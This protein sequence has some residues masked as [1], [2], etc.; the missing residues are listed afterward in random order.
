MRD[1]APDTFAY[2]LGDRVGE[3]METVLE[4]RPIEGEKDVEDVLRRVGVAD[5]EVGLEKVDSDREPVALRVIARGDQLDDLGNV[6]R[7]PEI[8]G[9]RHKHVGAVAGVHEHFLVDRDGPPEV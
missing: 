1:A 6:A 3:P 9:D 5:G 2:E 8:A 4:L 7:G